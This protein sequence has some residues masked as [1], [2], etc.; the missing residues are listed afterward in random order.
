M[1]PTSTSRSRTRPRTTTS[2]SRNRHWVFTHGTSTP[3][4]TLA[5]GEGATLVGEFRTVLAYPLVVGAAYFNAYLV[6]A[7]GRGARVRGQVYACSDSALNSL[8]R[9]ENA[10][11]ATSATSTSSQQYTRK[12]IRVASCTDR[13][14]VV[15]VYAYFK[16]H[17][18]QDL[19]VQRYLQPAN[20][21]QNQRPASNQRAGTSM[22]NSRSPPRRSNNT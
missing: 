9:L 2:L 22:H 6:D 16:R 7:P 14:F 10:T 11:S 18:A 17:R 21:S 1:L 15:N 12:I 20:S 5:L 4:T 13:S 8:D 19:V 3:H